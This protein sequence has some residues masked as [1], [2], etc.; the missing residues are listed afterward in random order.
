MTNR[1]LLELAAKAVGY[2]NKQFNCYEGPVDWDAIENQSDSDMLGVALELDVDWY[3]EMPRVEVY[4][5]VGDDWI[6][7]RPVPHDGTIEDKA[8]ALRLARVKVAAQIG[9]GIS[10]EG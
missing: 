6:T 1:K 3:K 5:W 10:D 9:G 2:W 8:R 7:S 4:T